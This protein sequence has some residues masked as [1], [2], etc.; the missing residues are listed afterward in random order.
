M[1]CM[2]HDD[3]D[4]QGLDPTLA[5]VRERFYWS[6]MNQEITGYVTNSYQCHVTNGHYTG[7]HTQQGLLVANNP[8]DLLFINFFES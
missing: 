5:L 4:N 6:A 7:L 3:C 1:L 8:W 2:L